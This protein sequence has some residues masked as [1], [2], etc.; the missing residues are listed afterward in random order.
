MNLRTGILAA[1]FAIIL[2]T[3]P[4]AAPADP[5]ASTSVLGACDIGF[6]VTS[7][8]HDFPGSARCQPFTVGIVRD[9]SGKEVIPVLRVEVPVAGMSTRNGTRDRQMREMFQSDRYPGIRGTAHDVDVGRFR[10]EMGKGGEGKVP[11]D[12]VLGIREAERKVH[13]MASGLKTS[14]DRVTFDLEFPVSLGEFGLTPP[15]VF[16]IIRVGD[17]VTV[18]ARF[19]LTVPG[20]PSGGLNLRITEIPGEIPGGS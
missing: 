18:K 9:A 8:L 7:T 16:G 11:L 10:A 15:T 4:E 19:T 6:F 13:A 1:A 17:K 20:P 2:C 3:P 5:S 12:L 14:G